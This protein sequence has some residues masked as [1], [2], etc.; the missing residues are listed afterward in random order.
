MNTDA[1]PSTADTATL[2]TGRIAFGDQGT[3]SMRLDG[4][5]ALAS[6]GRPP[7]QSTLST[8]ALQAAE[9]LCACRQNAR[10]LSD[11]E[12]TAITRAAFDVDLAFLGLAVLGQ[13]VGDGGGPLT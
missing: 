13:D 1:D 7:W 12:A 10:T 4:E 5:L 3:G 2:L 11:E 6:A 8:N 9:G